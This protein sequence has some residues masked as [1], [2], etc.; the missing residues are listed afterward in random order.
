MNPKSF[1]VMKRMV[2]S[3]GKIYM[4]P[5][6]NILHMQRN[7][8]GTKVTIGVGLDII[9]DILAG[10][11]V[12]GLILCDRAE[13]MRIASELGIDCAPQEEPVEVRE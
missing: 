9:G 7:R 11:Y 3:G 1:D 10:N 4:T 13:F 2:E 5:L 12:G 6:N 8:R